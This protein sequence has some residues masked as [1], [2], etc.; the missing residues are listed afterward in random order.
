LPE[1]E[2]QGVGENQEGESETKAL[3]LR[4]GENQEG[5]SETIALTRRREGAEKARKVNQKRKL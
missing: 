3:T 2:T 1:W 5:E 4:R